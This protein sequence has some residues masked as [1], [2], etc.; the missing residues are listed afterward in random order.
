MPLVYTED[1]IFQIRNANARYVLTDS[2]HAPKIKSL[3]EEVELKVRAN[4]VLHAVVEC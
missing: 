3:L 4:L 2:E 1:L